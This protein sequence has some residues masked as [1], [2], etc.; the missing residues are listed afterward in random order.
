MTPKPDDD[1]RDESEGWEALEEEASQGSLSPSSELEEALR[2]AA[3]AVEAR[4]ASRPNRRGAAAPS[5]QELERLQAELEALKDRHLRLQAD[6]ENHRRRTLNEREESARYGHENLVKD[7]LPTVDNLERAIDHA[8]QSGGGDFE[9]M[10]QG[11]ELVQR[12]LLGALAKH[13]VEPIEPEGQPF[14]PNLHEAMAQ[15]ATDEVPSGT[16][17]RVL[18]KGYALRDRL[19]RPARVMVSKRATQEGQQE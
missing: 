16:V 2:E 5:P 12:E 17:V 14:D 1:R 19:L 7:L 4:E 6:Y 3:E 11:V 9:S 18:Q 10:L 15:E 8:R 13:G